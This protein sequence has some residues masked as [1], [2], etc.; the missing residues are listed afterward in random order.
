MST[1]IQ[2]R[3]PEQVEQPQQAFCNSVVASLLASPKTIASKWFYDARGSALFE[4]ICRQP[5]YY[6]PRCEMEI[7]HSHQQDIAALIGFDST[8]I[9][10]GSGSSSKI[11]LLLSA[12]NARR[13]LAVDISPAALQS[14]EKRLRNAHPSLHIQTICADYSNGLENLENCLPARGRRLLFYPGSTL[15]NFDPWAAATFLR[16]WHRLLRVGDGLLLGIDLHKP[17]S[18]LEAAYNDKEGVT[19]R[20]NLNLTERIRQAFN[21]NIPGDA[22]IHK[23]FYNEPSRRIEMHLQ[24]RHALTLDLAG[25]CIK[26]AANETIHTENSYKYTPLVLKRLLNGSGFSPTA[27]WHDTRHWFGLCYATVLPNP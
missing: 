15:G 18:I 22:F 26:F 12:T 5:E 25:T 6:P 9:E 16:Q 27:F 3:E 20:F 21:I 8:I 17:A 1:F 19:A 11:D 2:N 4:Q 14:I 24:C 13:Y 10:P 7:L 23:A